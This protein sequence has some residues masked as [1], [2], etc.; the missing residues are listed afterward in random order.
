M[1][2]LTLKAGNRNAGLETPA[3]LVNT[4][5]N[6]RMA[7]PYNLYRCPDGHERRSYAAVG[8]D[9]TGAPPK[10]N[11]VWCVEKMDDG[12]M[13]KERAV[14]VETRY[15]EQLNHAAIFYA[16]DVEFARGTLVKRNDSIFTFKA[17]PF[18]E[19]SAN[20]TVRLTVAVHRHGTTPLVLDDCHVMG[21]EAGDLVLIADQ[22]IGDDPDVVDIVSLL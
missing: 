17:A 7:R 6:E 12:S 19:S 21:S 15:W 1:S 11:T 8:V 22:I 3:H 16:N 5:W 20:S 18:D 2:A 10:Q 4:G 14:F 9:V 13:C